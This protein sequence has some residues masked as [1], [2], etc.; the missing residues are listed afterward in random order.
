MKINWLVR[1]KNRTWWLAMIPAVLLLIQVVASVFGYD[2]DFGDLGNKLK[3]V[4]NAAF[5]VL[6]LLGIVNDPT[7][8]SLSDSED[9]LK[10]E[11]PKK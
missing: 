4:V 10:Y 6:T 11:E 3:D 1:I 9:A 8:D 7:T 5:V 2:L